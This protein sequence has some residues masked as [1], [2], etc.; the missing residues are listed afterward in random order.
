MMS[1]IP[2]KRFRPVYAR[3][4]KADAYPKLRA[5]PVNRAQRLQ[6]R[7]ERLAD[8]RKRQ[9]RSPDSA[10]VTVVDPNT[11]NYPIVT[12]TVTAGTSTMT[13][14]AVAESTTTVT[15]TETVLR[16]TGVA[17]AVTIT[18]PTRTITRTKFTVI[19]EVV[20]TATHNPTLSLT[21]TVLPSA[22]VS[23]CKVHGGHWS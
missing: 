13:V 18:K 15:E 11:A 6:E 10:T 17:P 8:V 5:V 4:V 2:E 12:S 9:K 23:A 19:T 21:S 3:G 14:T 1:D 7:K 16:G 20:A 22:S